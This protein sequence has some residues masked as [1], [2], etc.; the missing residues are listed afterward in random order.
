MEPRVPG[1][2]TRDCLQAADEVAEQNEPVGERAVTAVGRNQALVGSGADRV[3][4]R[5]DVAS[6]LQGMLAEQ[7]RQLLKLFMRRRRPDEL[8]VTVRQTRA[9]KPPFVDEGED[10]AAYFADARLPRLRHGAYLFVAKLRE[11]PHVLRR[12]DDDLLPVEGRV[13]VGDDPH[14]P[15]V[16]DP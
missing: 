11:G 8:R 6:A 14:L 12:V 1:P 2:G 16:T 13:E 15:R 3:D 10:V 4:G 9:C 7:A 5:D